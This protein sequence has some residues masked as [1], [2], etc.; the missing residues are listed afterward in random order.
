MGS[1]TVC[2]ERVIR[3]TPICSDH[4]PLTHDYCIGNFLN[5]GVGHESF[6]GIA[7]GL[8]G[9][10]DNVGCASGVGIKGGGPVS[11]MILKLFLFA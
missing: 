2:T 5:T 9:Y 11:V 1:I 6:F 8:T 10:V 3:Y 4:T 7:R